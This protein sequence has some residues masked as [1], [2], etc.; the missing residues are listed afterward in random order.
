MRAVD[1]NTDTLPAEEIP[2]NSPTIILDCE[3]PS[4]TLLISLSVFPAPGGKSAFDFVRAAGP[5]NVKKIFV[6]D[7]Y[8]MWYQKGTPDAGPDVPSIAEHLRS[9]VVKENVCR[10]VMIGNSGGGFAAILLGV[11]VGVDEVHAF[12]PPTRLHTLDDTSMPDQFRALER[13]MGLGSP[14][15]DLR[16]ILRQH[17]TQRTKIYIHYSRGDRK[18]K[19][20]AQYLADFPGVS[21]IEYPFVSHHVARFF[22]QRAMLSPLL[23]AAVSGDAVSLHRITRRMKLRAAPFY[24][25]GRVLW[26]YFRIVRKLKKMFSQGRKNSPGA[27]QEVRGSPR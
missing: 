9:L 14:Y 18:D 22:A 26:L 4:D 12:N 8:M 20:H 2:D 5:L 16:E 21:L 24:L 11:L 6:R 3:R 17:L 10:V 27:L 15:L 23:Q 13:E 1:M 25:P 19:R 7:P